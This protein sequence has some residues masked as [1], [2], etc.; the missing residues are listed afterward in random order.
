MCN[1]FLRSCLRVKS[2]L[3]ELRDHKVK[4]I[5]LHKLDFLLRASLQIFK[6]RRDRVYKTSLIKTITNI[7]KK[8]SPGQ[9][10]KAGFVY[11]HK[12][13]SCTSLISKMHSD[14]IPLILFYLCNLYF[15]PTIIYRPLAYVVGRVGRRLSI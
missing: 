10:R 6:G 4:Q 7:V 1:H 8:M 11:L 15:K 3:K 14:L 13:S 9:G 5:E 2:K 12:S